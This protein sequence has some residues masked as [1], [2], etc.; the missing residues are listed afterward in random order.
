MD[1]FSAM[2]LAQASRGNEMKVFD[3]AKAARRIKEVKPLRAEAGLS[4][5]WEYTGGIIYQNGAPIPKDQTYTYLASTWATPQLEMD[6]ETESCYVMMSQANG[7][8]ESTYWPQEA[9][10]ILNND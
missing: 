8:D 6:G 2:L 9:L 1:T 5:D 10:D 7:W 3:W 4:G